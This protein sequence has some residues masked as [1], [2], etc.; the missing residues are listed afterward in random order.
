MTL[1]HRNKKREY[2]KE[3]TSGLETE[4]RRR[5]SG[6]YVRDINK[7]EK[8]YQPRTNL[9]KDENGDLLAYSQNI[10]NRLQNYFCQ[11]LNV[12]SLNDLSQTEM[13]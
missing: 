6:T 11:L 5:I 7:F 2:L 13:H 8:G 10:L 3:N 9:V 1:L 4:V 12:L